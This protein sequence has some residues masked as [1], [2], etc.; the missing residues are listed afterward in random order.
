MEK[1]T[2]WEDVSFILASKCRE[3]V[4]KMLENPKTPSGISKEIKINKTHISRALKELRDKKIIVCLTP[5][6]NKGKLYII[7]GYGKKI[8]KKIKEL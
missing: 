1:V 6:S 7:S 2:K 4:L 3:D 8:L 5:N